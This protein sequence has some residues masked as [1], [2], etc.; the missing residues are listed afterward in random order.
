MDKISFIADILCTGTLKAENI[1]AYLEGALHQLQDELEATGTGDWFDLYEI[2]V[3]VKERDNA[4][5][6]SSSS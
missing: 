5:S 3:S 2:E 1:E 4:D 6:T